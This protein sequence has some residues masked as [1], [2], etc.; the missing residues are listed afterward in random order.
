MVRQVLLVI[1]NP[2]LET[3]GSRKLSV[4]LRWNDPDQLIEQFIGDV[5]LASHGFCSF[6]I[7]ERIEIDAFPVKVDGFQYTPES[8]VAKWQ[9]RSGFHTP[10]WADYR[11]IL[12]SVHAQERILGGEIDE[13][14]LIGFPYAGFYESQMAGPGAFW[15]NAPPLSGCEAVGRRFII[16]G[17][18]YERDVGEMLEAFGHRVESILS[19]VYRNKPNT[20]NLWERFTRYDLSHPGRAEVGTIH[21]AP[22]SRW[23]YDWGNREEVFSRCDT[24]RD[25]PDL[26]GEPR[27]VNCKE[28]GNGAIRQHHLWWL[29]H[30]PYFPGET[31]GVLNN[32]WYYVIEPG[33]AP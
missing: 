8:Y 12:T 11:K 13:V 16:M 19:H 6:Q 5:Y 25:F 3:R 7:A 29:E 1:Y 30:L 15:C 20:L 28:W 10:D 27:L 33:L 2:S 23:D 4:E 14:W 17:F 22:N 9:A 32:W 21:F 24:W 31:D 26:S 18:N